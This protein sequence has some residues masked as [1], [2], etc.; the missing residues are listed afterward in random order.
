MLPSSDY[1]DRQGSSDRLFQALYV[2]ENKS[3]NLLIH[4]LYTRIVLFWHI[5]DMPSRIW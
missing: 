1:T 5:G 2:F 3:Q 4:A